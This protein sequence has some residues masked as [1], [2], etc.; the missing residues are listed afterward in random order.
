MG[1][2]EISPPFWA[3]QNDFKISENKGLVIVIQGQK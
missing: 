3:T 2:F 1:T